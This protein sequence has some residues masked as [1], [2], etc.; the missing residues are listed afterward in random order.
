MGTNDL[1]QAIQAGKTAANRNLVHESEA[2]RQH[3][4]VRLPGQL[5]LS[6]AGGTG[7]VR[8]PLYDLSFGGASFL[9]GS[10]KVAQFKPGLTTAGQIVVSVDGIAITVPVT[11]QVISADAASGRV[12][13]RFQNLG[14]KQ[15][16]A[17]RQLINAYLAGEVDDFQALRR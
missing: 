12:G 17:L 2:Q 5:E 15:V 7:V 1:D 14:S 11:L 13:V 8:M 10:G 6:V 16:A 9:A 4:R 3:A